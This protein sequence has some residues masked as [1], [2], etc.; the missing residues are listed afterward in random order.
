MTDTY[1]SYDLV[2]FGKPLQ[3]RERT[4]PIPQGTEVLVRVRRSGVCH[5][6]L[7]IQEGFFDLG[8][9]GK[10]DMAER[11]MKLPQALGHEILGEVVAAGPEAEDA[12]IGQTMLVH[13]WIGCMQPACLACMSGR[14]NDCT[15][16]RAIGV[17]RDG[18]Y[19]EYVVVDH[20]KFLVD[21]E[22][23]DL[24]IVTPYACSGV[25]VYC[26]LKKVGL[27]EMNPGEWIAVMGAGGLGLNAVA[28]AKA[29]GFEKVVSCDV[30]PH[31]MQTA[32]SMGADAVLDTSREDALDELRKITGNQL[33]GVVDTVGIP[34]TARLSVHGLIKMGRYVVVGL[35][36]GDFKMPLPWLPQKSLT[37]RGSYVGS[38]NDLRELIEL[39]RTGKVA[40][41]PVSSRPL[42][43][44][45][46]TLDDLK[47]GKING[48]VVLTTD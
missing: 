36:G 8:E 7:H 41:I 3:A 23:L 20:P 18:G 12:P 31:K 45:S 30:D 32:I 38:C 4:M 42:S 22:G 47:A 21:I 19:G 27:E 15:R 1:T 43:A 48:R 35:H 40:E 9:E 16:M 28:I 13:P 2:E 17:V 46:D 34:I 14:E 33:L 6:D 11:G 5:S 44:A 25:T 39:V 10:L 29:M 37:V 26:A 24:D